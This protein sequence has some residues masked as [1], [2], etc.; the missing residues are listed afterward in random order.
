MS[1]DRS[2]NGSFYA[3]QILT[4]RPCKHCP[5]NARENTSIYL[6][7]SD[8]LFSA[9]K[10]NVPF[11]AIHSKYGTR[12]SP[13]RR[14]QIT[15]LRN[16]SF[17]DSLSMPLCYTAR[18]VGLSA[19]Y[20]YSRNTYLLVLRE[21]LHSYSITTQRDRRDNMRGPFQISSPTETNTFK[22]YSWI[23]YPVLLASSGDS[24]MTSPSQEDAPNIFGTTEQL[25]L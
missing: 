8:E 24:S 10:R 23:R 5:S 3:R 9:R 13:L 19:S 16:R 4:C 15:V 12:P 17:C 25:S 21:A 6:K 18:M 14:V 1:V 20:M 7:E 22:L 2:I 11:S